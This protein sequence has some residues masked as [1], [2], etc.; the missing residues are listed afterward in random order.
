M[1]PVFFP[2][3]QQVSKEIVGI[4]R[5]YYFNVIFNLF[6]HIK[7]TRED[8]EK[9]TAFLQVPF[10]LPLLTQAFF[11]RLAGIFGPKEIEI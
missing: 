7:F 3:D 1:D 2:V 4:F 6:P 5:D 8:E 11:F 10:G 9:K